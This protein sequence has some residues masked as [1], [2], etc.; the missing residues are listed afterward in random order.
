MPT[1]EPPTA[2]AIALAFARI[3]ALRA[4]GFDLVP[5]LQPTELARLVRGRELIIVRAEHNVRGAP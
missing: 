5:P 1:A 2:P 3:A 4:A